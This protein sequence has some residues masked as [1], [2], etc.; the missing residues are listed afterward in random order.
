MSEDLLALLIRKAIHTALSLLLLIPLAIPYVN[1]NL[2]KI[3][4][5]TPHELTV[6]CYS[7]ITMSVALINSFQIRVPILREELRKRIVDSRKK[8][9]DIISMI[10]KKS[11]LPIKEATKL[12]HELEVSISRFETAVSS[13][14]S[15]IERDYERKVGYIGATFGSLSVLISYILFNYLVIYGILALAI[16]DAL[17]PILTKLLNGPKLPMSKTSLGAMAIVAMVFT[18]TLY[19]LGIPLQASIVTSLVAVFTEAYSPEDNLTLPIAVS[20]SLYLLM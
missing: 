12:I 15:R 5:V 3:L 19:C 9:F 1:P 20:G 14:L 7:V 17:S 11:P 18:L 16:V 2:A 4:K 8:V 13:T 6:V 10:L